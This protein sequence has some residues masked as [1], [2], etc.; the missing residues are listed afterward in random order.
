MKPRLRIGVSACLLGEPVRYDGNSK[1]NRRVCNLQAENIELV[2]LCPEVAIGM[3]TPRAPIQLVEINNTIHALGRDDPSREFTRPLKRYGR[4]MAPA[5][6]DISGFIFKSRSP[7]CGLGSTPVYRSHRKPHKGS[8]LFAREIVRTNPL[9]PVTEESR[10]EERDHRLHFLEQA[11]ALHDWRSFLQSEPTRAALLNFHHQRRLQ[12]MAHG[13]PYLRTLEQ[14]IHS[15]ISQRKL[16][17]G[18][19]AGLMSCLRYRTSTAKQH[20]VLNHLCRPLRPLLSPQQ[21][22]KLQ[23]DLMDYR[24]HKI[25]L[26]RIASVIARYYHRQPLHCQAAEHYFSLTHNLQY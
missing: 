11:Y 8:G 6:S 13:L 22:S 12:L 2:P 7:S 20:H 21:W 9:L 19:G 16:V 1:R 17:G 5:M 14:L 18:Y 4:E 25:P 26:S 23:N 3:G 15:G 10:L 24:R